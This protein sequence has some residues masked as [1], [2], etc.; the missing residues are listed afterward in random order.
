VKDVFPWIKNTAPPNVNKGVFTNRFEFFLC[1][2]KGNQNK[3][4]PVSWQGKYHN[5]LEGSTAAVDNVTKGEHSATMPVYVP[6]WF[7]ERLDFVRS[8]YEPFTGSGTTLI[9]CEKT[10]RKCFGMEIDPH[11]CDVII[12]RWEKFTGK[13]AD[14][15]SDTRECHSVTIG[16]VGDLVPATTE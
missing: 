6:E 3:G 15:S 4:F 14:L 5:I 2:E 7:L 9:A 11:Y 8:V 13:V 12:A 10:G 1:L 16:N